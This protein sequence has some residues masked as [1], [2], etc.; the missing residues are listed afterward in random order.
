MQPGVGFAGCR[1][2]RRRPASTAQ[3]RADYGGPASS[4]SFWTEVELGLLAV[5][6]STFTTE[7]RLTS[8]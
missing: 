5:L 7:D 2:S 3:R 8:S 4:R 1:S 6:V